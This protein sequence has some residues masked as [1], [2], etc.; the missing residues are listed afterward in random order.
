MIIKKLPTEIQS[1]LNG[2]SKINNYKNAVEELVYNSLDADATSV[3]VRIHIYESVIQVIDNGFGIAKCDIPLLGER[4]ASSKITDKSSFKSAPV[5]FGFRGESLSNIIEVSESVKITTRHKDRDETWV[6]IFYKGHHKN[7][8]VTSMRPSKGTTVEIKGFLYNLH[9]QK[10]A[11]NPLKELQNIKLLLQQLSLVNT[12]VSISLRDDSKNEILFKVHKNRDVYQTLYSVFEIDKIDLQELQIEKHQYKAIGFISKQN[13]NI[14]SYQWIYLNGRFLKKCHLH[15]IINNSFIKNKQ[16]CRN[17]KTKNIFLDFEKNL[18]KND[19]PTYFIFITCPYLDYDINRDS[20]K[21]ITEFKN[22]KQIRELLEKLVQF[23]KGDIKLNKLE[24]SQTER[25]N[26]IENTREEVRK[27]IEKVLGNKT[28]GH[29]ISQLRKGVKGKIVKKKKNLNS[30]S[31]KG[32]KKMHKVGKKIKETDH[33][34]KE[35]LSALI[36]AP[37]SMNFQVPIK[38]TE[39]ANNLIVK[40]FFESIKV[41]GKNKPKLK[42]EPK[43]QQNKKEKSVDTHTNNQELA[44]LGYLS[45]FKENTS[46]VIEDTA[47]DNNLLVARNKKTSIKD[48]SFKRKRKKQKIDPIMKQY[49]QETALEMYSEKVKKKKRKINEIK[50]K[51]PCMFDAKGDASFLQNENNI[52]TFY[53][54]KL[55]FNGITPLNR[56]GKDYLKSGDLLNT[57]LNSQKVYSEENIVQFKRPYKN[58]NKFYEKRTL[59]QKNCIQSIERGN[60]DIVNDTVYR[61]ND[62]FPDIDYST[63]IRK[64][65]DNLRNIQKCFEN[66]YNNI[67]RD[68]IH[69]QNEWELTSNLDQYDRHNDRNTHIN[70]IETNFSTTH[71]YKSFP[72]L[73]FES[74]KYNLN[75]AMMRNNKLKRFISKQSKDNFNLHNN[76][77]NNVTPI[78]KSHFKQHYNNRSKR[79]KLNKNPYLEP[80]KKVPYYEHKSSHTIEFSTNM[81]NANKNTSL[82]QWKYKI[83]GN[84]QNTYTII[85]SNVSLDIE[86]YL[87]NLNTNATLNQESV[88]SYLRYNLSSAK[89]IE[90]ETHQDPTVIQNLEENNL[91]VNIL[92]SK[93]PAFNFTEKSDNQIEPINLC[94][95]VYFNNEVNMDKEK[96]IQDNVNYLATGNNTGH[97][98]NNSPSYKNDVLSRYF[99]TIENIQNL[100]LNDYPNILNREQSGK[101]INQLDENQNDNCPV[102]DIADKSGNVITE[103]VI[104]SHFQTVQKDQIL[105]MGK[106]KNLFSSEEYSKEKKNVEE[107]QQNEDSNLVANNTRIENGCNIIEVKNN[108]VINENQNMDTENSNNSDTVKSSKD[109]EKIISI[110]DNQLKNNELQIVEENA[111]IMPNAGNEKRKITE[112]FKLQR[113]HS[114]VPKGMSPIFENCNNK[115]ICS[116]NLETDYF[117]DDLYNNFANDVL[118]NIKIYENKVSNMSEVTKKIN[119]DPNCL[120]FNTQSLKDA[121][122]FG[123]V[124]RKFICAELKSENI[125]MKHLVLFD[126]HAV[127]ERISLEENLSDYKDVDQ[128]HSI[129]CETISL[130]LSKDD[131]LYL[132]NFRDKFKQFGLDW[133]I[134]SDSLITINAVPKA[135]FG[136]YCRQ[137]DVIIQSIKKLILEEIKAIKSQGGNTLLYPKSIMDLVYSEACRYAIKFGEKLSKRECATLISTLSSCRTPFQCAHGRPVLAVLADVTTYDYEYKVDKSKILKFRNKM[138]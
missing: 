51:N 13:T 9:I 87:N 128:W 42:I 19:I 23:Y 45:N 92:N 131:V 81:Y 85:D 91:E 55:A 3:A 71:I 52:H 5:K 73:T 35:K 97:V 15:D 21:T 16:L 38:N 37:I 90:K 2:S 109:D 100:S 79:K 124:D 116:Y 54:H 104:S 111:E 135:L 8:Q 115:N 89:L 12:N 63:Y 121:K 99:Q 134:E 14:S 94:E 40:R 130:K 10:R 60:N 65:T 59:H 49:T 22:W 132:N 103:E 1:L 31:K 136:K 6:K 39:N 48:I 75:D 26:K 105:Q 137:A 95:A 64:Q 86:N 76:Q 20:T 69:V 106:S 101:K 93:M 61:N 72:K 34:P 119:K 24:V 7:S 120:K 122:V 17:V 98:S 107:R 53:E 25:K 56:V 96:T 102:V 77:H 30:S 11:T 58:Q 78:N 84:V 123:Q 108:N 82:E 110:E 133:K 41:K 44:D 129:N 29:E 4:Y 80:T 125:N 114:F 83:T 88:A 70:G 18:Q 46:L 117:Q 113:R 50:D 27:I 138:A 68:I 127:H 28:K 47:K 118:D 126:Q 32:F 67:E 33:N 57:I 66:K 43:I 62:Q 36:E 112:N 74:H